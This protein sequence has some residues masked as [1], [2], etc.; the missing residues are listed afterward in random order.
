MIDR[1]EK[2]C[3]EIDGDYFIIFKEG[4]PNAAEE[5]I[6]EFERLRKA[7]QDRKEVSVAELAELFNNF[8]WIEFEGVTVLAIHPDEIAKAI[9]D[10]YEVKEKGNK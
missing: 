10:K 9:L 1:K 8:Q 2:E 6:A 7:E 5:F 3:W 4:V